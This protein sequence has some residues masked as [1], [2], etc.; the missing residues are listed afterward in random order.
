VY[1]RLIDDKVQ[2]RDF[3]KKLVVIFS[4]TLILLNCSDKKGTGVDSNP[5]ISFSPPIIQLETGEQGQI[6]LDFHDFN[7]DIFA[8]SM[9]ISCD[10]SIA[11]FNESTDFTSGDFF[12]Q[13]A[14]IFVRNENDTIYL[15]LSLI[16]GTTPVKG[17]GTLANFNFTGNS[18]G[19]TTL[20]P[21]ENQLYF[22]D[23]DGND[24]EILNLT[25]ESAAIE[26]Q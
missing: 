8:V 14:V 7:A 25:I 23:E 12:G 18:A 17:S 20:I 10:S 16:Q 24:I 9:Q 4:V 2:R 1:C 6:S 15:T 5:V 3:M 26:V 11:S 13:D 21:S 22:Y 19:S